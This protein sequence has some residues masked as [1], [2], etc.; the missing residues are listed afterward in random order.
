MC[1]RL[2]INT[3][4]LTILFF[5][6]F[7]GVSFI[8]VFIM[9]KNTSDTWKIYTGV[10]TLK[11]VLIV[12]V[13]AMVVIALG[14][15]GLAVAYPNIAQTAI[16]QI[17]SVFQSGTEPPTQATQ[18][19]TEPPTDPQPKITV[20]ADSTKLEVGKTCKLNVTETAGAKEYNVRYDTTDAN[21]AAVDAQGV[22]TAKSM[23]ECEVYAYA[24]G[25]QT[26]KQTIA[27]T[28]TDNRIKDINTLNTYLQG[29]SP[30][31]QYTYASTK[32]GK[33]KIGKSRIDDF[34]KDKEYELIVIHNLTE[35]LTKAELVTLQNNN[36][37][38]YKTPA[39]Y[40]N[41]ANG[42]YAS[43]KEDVYIDENNALCI[44]VEYRKNSTSTYENTA[45][46]Y[47]INGSTLK[48]Q[49]TLTAVQPQKP[50]DTKTK[51]SYK[52]DNK[53]IT[54][55]EYLNAY[56]Q[57]KKNKTKVDSYIDGAV[58][59][60]QGKYVKAEI[61]VDLGEAYLNRI[62]WQC[63]ND[64][65]AQVGSG[66]VITGKAAGDCI[67]TGRLDCFA[68]PIGRVSVTVSAIEDEYNAYLRKVKDEAITGE[69]GVTMK[70]YGYQAFDVDKD[71]KKEMFLYYTGNNSCQ[72]DVVT[73]NNSQ[74]QRSVAINK[75]T[76]KGTV[77]TLDFY[78]N[79]SN[80]QIM[81][82]EGYI[83]TAAA[84]NETEFYYDTYSDRVFSQTSST[85]KVEDSQLT[86]D[87][88]TYYIGGEKVE[89]AAFGGAVGRY[90]KYGEWKIV[91][92]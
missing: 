82:Y 1:I 41:I 70:L 44:I 3:K 68:K 20:T 12:T 85:Y 30:V 78:T 46:L 18:T 35:E 86:S 45:V 60:S 81:L 52:K 24:D 71:S 76:N 77:C 38:A 6:D 69:N 5:V 51:S 9:G 91:S 29:L 58:S 39:S 88:R 72:I 63:D 25:Y 14:G 65:V 73:I 15:A 55:D 7:I 59:V 26:D 37:V 75:S 13:S 67:V 90:K 89:E 33:A 48:A 16:N 61:P 2:Q 42:G 31:E 34:N 87:K 57:L 11:K 40:T 64:D 21:I 80:S 4:K 84:G 74:V 92:D 53:T 62:K 54:Q 17:T 10:G 56:T 19:K 47:T 36:A 23:G 83:T 28:V 50:D 8:I 43:Y 27:F 32:T 66:G 49:E 22:V 79:L